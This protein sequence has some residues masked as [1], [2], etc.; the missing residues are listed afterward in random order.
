MTGA[1]IKGGKIRKI[2]AIGLGLYR[3]YL[4]VRVLGAT[5]DTTGGVGKATPPLP[6]HVPA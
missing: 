5:F 6:S 1:Q 2:V 4:S 3:L